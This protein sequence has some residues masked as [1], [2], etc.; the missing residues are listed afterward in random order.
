V[1]RDRF[2]DGFMLVIGMLVGTLL[3]ALVIGVL[4]VRGSTGA[5]HETA[6]TMP[7]SVEERI[8]PVGRL[9]LRGEEPASETVQTAAQPPP[10]ATRL[11]GPQ[12]YNAACNLCHAPPG[13]GGAP[14]LGD[15]AAWEARVAQGIEVLKEHALGGYQGQTGFMPAKGGRVDLSDQEVTDAVEFMVGEL[16]Q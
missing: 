14:P 9:V 5:H 7:A 8:A 16:P 4:V 1:S 6:E 15:S 13:I 10:V 12:V 11:T 3:G 2:F